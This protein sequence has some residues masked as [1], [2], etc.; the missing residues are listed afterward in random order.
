LDGVTTLLVGD[1]STEGIATRLKS[2]LEDTTDN[3]DG[4]YAGRKQSI[5]SNVKRMDR[6]I[7]L[8]E[9]RLEKREQNLYDQYNALEQL[10]SSMNSTS[11]YLSTQLASLENLWSYNK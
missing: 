6:S 7:E 11:S 10:I 1:D 9:L 2:Y 4:F 8:M 5:E 3:I